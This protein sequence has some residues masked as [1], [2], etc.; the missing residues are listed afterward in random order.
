M[1]QNE[2]KPRRIHIII[3]GDDTNINLK[4]PFFMTKALLNISSFIKEI[5]NS[6]MDKH[7][8]MAIDMGISVL[9]ILHDIR[10]T[11]PLEMVCIEDDEST[12]FI[13]LS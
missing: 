8:Q 11:E 13:K 1:G 12:V 3:R 2:R 10:I 6:S 5:S 9:Q 7:Q 4:I